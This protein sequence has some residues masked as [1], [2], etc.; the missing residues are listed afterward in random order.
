MVNV[1]QYRNSDVQETSSTL[2]ERCVSAQRN[3]ATFPTIWSPLLK[4]HPLVVGLPTNTGSGGTE[5]AGDSP[6]QQT[7]NALRFC[8]RQIFAGLASNARNLS[9]GTPSGLDA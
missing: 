9:P 5:Y 8:F 6:I 3:G 1:Q 4:G 2:L 7:P